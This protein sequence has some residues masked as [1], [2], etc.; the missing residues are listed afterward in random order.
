M[1]EFYI[2]DRK[3]GVE[4]VA[5]ISHITGGRFGYTKGAIKNSDGKYEFDLILP[6]NSIPSE[7]EKILEAHGLSKLKK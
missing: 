4:E 6:G 5:E 3:L 7:V 1:H 2:S